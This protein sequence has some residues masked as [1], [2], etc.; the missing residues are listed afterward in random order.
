MSTSKL[1]LV[2]S[3]GKNPPS[4]RSGL[5]GQSC[6]RK[7]MEWK[8]RWFSIK[9]SRRVDCFIIGIRLNQRKFSGCVENCER[10]VRTS[11]QATSF[12]KHWVPW[13]WRNTPQ[14]KIWHFGPMRRPRP[15]W[16]KP[17]TPAGYPKWSFISA[18]ATRWRL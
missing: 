18:K 6:E 13:K 9:W 2:P 15:S 5:R 10:C 7:E 3:C 12:L 8:R 11:I 14:R 1:R 17:W 16:K 4:G